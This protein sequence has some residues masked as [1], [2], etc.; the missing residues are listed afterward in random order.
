[1]GRAH[2][3]AKKLRQNVKLEANM[4]LLPGSRGIGFLLS[5]PPAEDRRML[6]EGYCLWI[7]NTECR[8]IRNNVHTFQHVATDWIFSKSASSALK[9]SKTY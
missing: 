8:L 6:E 2:D 7:S 9:K 1:M 3:L 4:R 5:I